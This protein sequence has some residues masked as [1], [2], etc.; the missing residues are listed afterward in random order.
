MK[1]KV[2]DIIYI[3]WFR[4]IGDQKWISI[5]GVPRLVVAVRRGYYIIFNPIG[6]V[7]EAK[8]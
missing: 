6:Q 7:Y 5:H 2:G 1:Y 4:D 3:N 8:E